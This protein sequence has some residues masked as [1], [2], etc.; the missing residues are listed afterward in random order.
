M[1]RGA[2]LGFLAKHLTSIIHKVARQLSGKKR[3]QTALLRAF[4]ATEM[5]IQ[6]R[7]VQRVVSHESDSVRPHKPVWAVEKPKRPVGLR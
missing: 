1:D 6:V 4:Q 3:R 5:G 2:F 7:D